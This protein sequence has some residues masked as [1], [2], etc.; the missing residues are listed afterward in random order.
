[1]ARTRAHGRQRVTWRNCDSVRRIAV[2]GRRADTCWDRDIARVECVYGAARE[3]AQHHRVDGV[4]Q[5][6]E[7]VLK[8]RNTVVRQIVGTGVSSRRCRARHS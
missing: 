8:T 4:V 7:R 6:D 1:M 3:H 2:G 5:G